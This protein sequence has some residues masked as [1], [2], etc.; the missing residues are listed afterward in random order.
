MSDELQISDAVARA[1]EGAARDA[2]AD[3]GGM[4]TGFVALTT[5]LNAQGERCWSLSVG[6][7]QGLAQSLGMADILDMTVRAQVEAAFFG[8][9]G[10]DS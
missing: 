5:Y 6:A 4:V 10:G 3:A 9:P 7:D 8:D 1:M 2:L